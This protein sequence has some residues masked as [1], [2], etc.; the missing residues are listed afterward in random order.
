MCALEGL[1]EKRSR[2]CTG[3]QHETRHSQTYDEGSEQAVVRDVSITF[4]SANR[5]AASREFARDF[6]VRGVRYRHIGDARRTSSAASASR[7]ANATVPKTAPACGAG[8][9]SLIALG[10]K[11]PAGD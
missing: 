9:W 11:L 10:P 4:V 7:R 2:L 6:P 5:Y 8:R 3:R 1:D